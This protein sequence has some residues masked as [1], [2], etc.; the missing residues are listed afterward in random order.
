M[1]AQLTSLAASVRGKV[2]G[3]TFRNVGGQTIISTTSSS[4]SGRLSKPVPHEVT[5]PYSYIK[6]YRSILAFVTQSWSKLSAEERQSWRK[7]GANYRDAYNKFVSHNY[8]NK[9]IVRNSAIIRIPVTPVHRELMNVQIYEQYPGRY[10][11]SFTPVMS[12]PPFFIF[13]YS[14]PPLPVS[15]NSYR[16]RMKLIRSAT[17][18]TGDVALS[19]IQEIFFGK[20]LP[21]QKYFIQVKLV[22]R[23]SGTIVDSHDLS[24]ITA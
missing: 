8:V 20:L 17:A 11:L 10:R 13:Q 21:N 19:E 12:P 22:H 3:S 2:A 14:S 7:D 1:K 5:S 4:L 23:D 9:I 15:A 16:K 18:Q 24:Y 6:N